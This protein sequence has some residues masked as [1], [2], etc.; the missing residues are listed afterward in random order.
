MSLAQRGLRTDQI[1]LRMTRAEIGN[2]LGM[3][4]ET[5]SRALS[6][7]ARDERH[8]L[9]R[10]GPPRHPHPRRRRPVDLRPA[11]PRAGARARCSRPSGATRPGRRRGRSPA[12]APRACRACAAAPRPAGT[13]R[14]ASSSSAEK[15][16]ISSDRQRPGSA[17][18]PRA[19]SSV[20]RMPAPSA[21]SVSS[22]S[23]RGRGS[24]TSSACSAL[25]A[26]ADAAAEAVEE[27]AHHGAHLG[28]VLDQQHRAGRRGTLAP[29]AACRPARPRGIG[30]RPRH[31]ERHASCRRPA[32]CRARPR[33]ATA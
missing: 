16:D 7:L 30:D 14:S 31:V 25:A 24:S 20:P 32:R 21:M 11:L 33:R 9:R 26:V 29:D 1:T 17:P 13:S 22:R 4:L 12:P 28:V 15:P 19:A 8:R 3:T 6:K 27:A 10:E 2:Y 23:K 5:V 18:A